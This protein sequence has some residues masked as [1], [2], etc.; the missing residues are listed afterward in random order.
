MVNEWG[1]KSRVLFLTLVP[2]IT[3]SLLLSAYF[4]STR[5][6]DLEKALRDRGYAIALQMAPASEYGVFSGNTHTLQRLANDAL[7]EPEVRSVAIFDKDGRLLAHAGHEQQTPTN[8]LSVSDQ[9]HGITMADTGN[10]LLFTVPV[11][12]RDVIIEDYAYV[13]SPY[14]FGANHDSVLGWISIE[15]GRMTTT[16][17]QY[18]VLFACSI[19]VMIGLGISGIFAFRMGRDVTRPILQMASAVEKIK[20]GNFD[21]RVYTNARSE[22]RHLE[23]GINTMAAALKAAHEEMQ[24]SVEQATADLRQ[25][26]ETIEIQNIELEMARKEAE[27]ASRVKSEFLANMSHEIRTPLNGVIGFINLLMKTKL[28]IRQNDY[29][30]TIHKSAFSLLSIINDILDFSKIEAGKLSLDQLPMDLRECVEDAL[31]LMAPNAHEKGLELVPMI[32]TD[33]PERII[34]DHL[35]L[36][37]I[38]TNLV[39]NA[40][41]FTEKGNVVVRIMLEKEMNDHVIICVSITDSGIGLSIDEQKSLFQAFTQADST[42]T[43]R[44][45]G[46]GLGLVISK[47]LVQQMGGEIGVESE[48][49]KGSTFWFTFKA[50]KVHDFSPDLYHPLLKNYRILV[51]EPHATTRLSLNHLIS[52]WG[53]TVTEIAEPD[54]I[55]D[56]LKNAMENQHPFHMIIIGI[57]QLD[58]QSTFI[59]DLTRL[60]AD[61]FDCRVCVLA[62]TTDQSIDEAMQN[63]GVAVYLAK[64]VRRIKLHDALVEVLIPKSTDLD[65]GSLSKDLKYPS[66]SNLLEVSNQISVLAV[67]DYPSNLKLV[68]ALLEN[69]GVSAD[70]ANNGYEALQFIEKKKYD[71]IFMDIQMPGID[72]IEVTN[73]IRGEEDPGSHIPII[74]L[75]A[76]ALT[77]EKEAVLRAGMD[78][79]LTKPID[80]KDLQRI[81]EQWTKK[82]LI[83]SQNSNEQHQN[84]QQEKP[85]IPVDWQLTLKL[86]ANKSSLAKDMLMGLVDSLKSAQTQIN[87]SFTKKDYK[88][89]REHVHRLHGACC[90]CGVPALKTAVA[91]VETAIAQKEYD[92]INFLV[93]ELNKEINRLQRYVQNNK[94]LLA[95]TI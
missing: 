92:N 2:T 19:I 13:E 85:R 39:N 77:T 23:A 59:E 9:S 46:T 25:T 61:K 37:Q 91:S 18:Q 88:N 82:I 60:A 75:T 44:F 6:Q 5:I 89:M 90:Y 57:N 47:R 1:I 31:I 73:R 10:S 8:I 14:D 20:N 71:L 58:K 21:T 33:V 16:I 32:Y 38:M 54:Q 74:A 93:V 42:T 41:K 50:S 34:G 69:L 80:E 35:R 84:T 26:L 68:A 24:Q 17:R 43:R 72:G 94:E 87:Q 70:C 67:D 66:D 86:A 40:I 11:T 64:P 95:V 27:T 22:L 56:T 7:S 3:I 45:G 62:N 48:A 55:V 83:H 52:A 65:V 49:G 79:Y 78:D 63:A 30:S 15:L 81:I 53:T 12:M 28:D 29:L 76:H 4:T 36:K 51:H